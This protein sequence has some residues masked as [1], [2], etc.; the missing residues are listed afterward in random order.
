MAK[1]KNAY[2]M[3]AWILQCHREKCLPASVFS[4][5]SK[6]LV[7]RNYRYMSI[8]C[9]SFEMGTKPILVRSDK[10]QLLSAFGLL[11]KM[12]WLFLKHSCKK[13]RI[14]CQLKFGQ[15][16]NHP[17]KQKCIIDSFTAMSWRDAKSNYAEHHRILLFLEHLVLMKA[18]ICSSFKVSRT[19][20]YVR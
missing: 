13:Y 2:F 20:S 12:E 19:L 18:S 5:T 10:K 14:F 17:G 16:W 8:T 15:G 7:T 6:M 4:W 11:P 9:A 1:R 3:S